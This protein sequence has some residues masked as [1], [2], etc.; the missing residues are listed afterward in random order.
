MAGTEPCDWLAEKELLL[1]KVPETEAL[2]VL[3]LVSKG[4][5]ALLSKL[6]PLSDLAKAGPEKE[7]LGEE[8]LRAG[9]E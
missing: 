9:P 4:E 2:L 5:P 1:E 3:D 8:L 7:L 6:E